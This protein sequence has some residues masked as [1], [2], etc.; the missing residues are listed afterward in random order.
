MESF[1]PPSDEVDHAIADE[2]EAAE[3]NECQ[4]RDHRPVHEVQNSLLHDSES[5]T[6]NR[7]MNCAKLT[8][9]TALLPRPVRIRNNIR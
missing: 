5:P 2:D 4:S 1:V 8:E 6:G 9:G 3:R 7:E